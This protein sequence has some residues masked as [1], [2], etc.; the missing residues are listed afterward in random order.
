MRAPNLEERILEEW[1]LVNSKREWPVYF[2]DFGM[3]VDIHGLYCIG[4]EVVSYTMSNEIVVIPDG[5]KKI[6]S[7]AFAFN[8]YVRVIV[9]PESVELIDS[10]AIDQCPSLEKLVIKGGP[11][12]NRWGIIVCKNLDVIEIHG[13][14][15]QLGQDAV[16]E[17]K[18]LDFSKLKTLPFAPVIK[19]WKGFTKD[20]VTG[21][22]VCRG[23][24]YKE[25]ETYETEEAK[26]CWCGF[27]AC[28]DPLD[29]ASY[30]YGK[31]V[32]YHEVELSGDI[33]FPTE[34]FC[35]YDSKICATK[36]T[37]GQKVD[38]NEMTRSRTLMFE[39]YNK[40]CNE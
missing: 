30:Y 27:H 19:A 8:T 6:R 35:D 34:D 12:I 16:F 14:G 28:L 26:L 22:L 24:H 11:V 5:M 10:N 36:I 21:D 29:C 3:G 33:C 1:R 39:N 18:K 38:W 31:D 2:G 40:M 32:E 37:I 17:C 20:L 25:G 4:D 9:I 23:F 7:F 15:A 13:A